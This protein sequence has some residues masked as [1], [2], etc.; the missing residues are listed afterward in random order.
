MKHFLL[1]LAAL[2][3][4]QAVEKDDF[5][6]QRVITMPATQGVVKLELPLTLYSHFNTN[7]LQDLAVFDANNQAMPH[8]I[9]ARHISQQRV[10]KI[11]L[12]F[13]RVKTIKEKK[14]TAL[15]INYQGK[16]LTLIENNSINDEDYIL[17]ASQMKEG[18][19]Y[20]QISSNDSEY[21][22][23]TDITC[24]HD[25][26]HWNGLSSGQ[27]LA[28]IT[29]QENAIIKD[30]LTLNSSACNYL[31]IHT[32]HPLNI[33]TIMAY[34]AQMLFHQPDPEPLLIT[35]VDN[36]LEFSVSKQITLKEL[37]F[38]LPQKE[39]LYK[40]KLFSKNAT[41]SAWSFVKTIT[42][43]SLQNGALNNLKTPLFTH[44][45][46]YRLEAAE[47]S[48]LPQELQ[49]SFS[50]DPQ[51]LYFIA[52]GTPPYTLTYGSI[53]TALPSADLGNM[54]QPDTHFISATLGQE[55]LLNTEANKIEEKPNYTTI[56]VWLSL[57][58]GVMILSFMSYKLIKELKLNQEEHTD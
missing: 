5:A 4:L 56:L 52:Q 7:N 6:Y 11:S 26:S 36:G 16:E 49:L 50:Y 18:I 28:N 27:M 53:K 57:A 46:Y 54:I 1:F 21:M 10:Q 25:L 24:S 20:L 32:Q 15:N 37:H 13:S 30:R 55:R 3:S 45:G 58:V 44:A 23:M 48:Y 39:Q 22:L 8:M 31:K 35:K 41:A 33:N 29:M 34:K 17:D 47:N 43:Y 40:L 42:I 12:P 51:E 9:K 14:E 2:L 19:D 38:V